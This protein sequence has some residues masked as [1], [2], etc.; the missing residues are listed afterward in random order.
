LQIVV[1]QIFLA[2]VS[3]M[4]EGHNGI[5]HIAHIRL[6][7]ADS[8]PSQLACNPIVLRFRSDSSDSDYG[9]EVPGPN[10]AHAVK[11]AEL[12]QVVRIATMRALIDQSSHIAPS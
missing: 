1:V 8:D 9:L 12:S 4:V 5:D 7:C 3:E 11:A 6:V 10:S 2:E